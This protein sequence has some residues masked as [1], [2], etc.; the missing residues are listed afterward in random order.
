MPRCRR[1][2]RREHEGSMSL[3]TGTD[4]ASPVQSEDDASVI[5]CHASAATPAFP[6]GQPAPHDASAGSSSDDSF[7]ISEVEYKLPKLREFRQALKIPSTPLIADLLQ[8]EL[9]QAYP[10][11]IFA[12]L[13]MDHFLPLARSWHQ[14]RRGQL[15]PNLGVLATRYPNDCIRTSMYTEAQMDSLREAIRTEAWRARE[16]DDLM[17]ELEAAIRTAERKLQADRRTVIINT[18]RPPRCGLAHHGGAMVCVLCTALDVG[19]S[20]LLDSFRGRVNARRHGAL[21]GAETTLHDEHWDGLGVPQPSCGH[22]A[23]DSLDPEQMRA[24]RRREQHETLCST[25]NSFDSDVE[26][27]RA[28]YVNVGGLHVVVD[29]CEDT[30]FIRFQ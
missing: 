19:S 26:D 4:Y 5:S 29:A 13:C 25:P 18:G 22:A 17:E 1:E 27:P 7:S 20:N 11:D 15:E 30:P 2:P 16:T 28:A 8:L 6:G 3:P 10:H 21:R 12:T 14:R 24:L 9:Y 23:A